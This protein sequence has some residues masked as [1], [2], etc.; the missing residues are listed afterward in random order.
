[1]KHCSVLHVFLAITLNQ[2]VMDK[3][4]G[5]ITAFKRTDA[6]ILN[7]NVYIVPLKNF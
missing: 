4:N 2:M 5:R 7:H 6:N 3:I 1:M